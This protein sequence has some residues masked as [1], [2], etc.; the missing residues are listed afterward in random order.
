MRSVSQAFAVLR[1]LGE[2]APLTLSDI[3]R[4]L[5]L[6]ASSCFNLLGT[7]VAEGAVVREAPGKRYR[8]ADGWARSGLLQGGDARRMIDR[9]RPLM[10]RFAQEHGVTAGLWQV[11][12]RDRLQL[13]AHAESNAVLRIH[14]AQGQR[15]PLGGGAVGRAIAAA[16]TP[17]AEEIA[18]RFAAVRWEKPIAFADYAEQIRLAVRTGFALDDG[19]THIGIAT[20]AAVLPG[21]GAEYCLSAS[22]FAGARSG[23]EVTALGKAL[24]DL[25]RFEE[26]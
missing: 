3:A 8:L 4:S 10:M 7:L 5:G 18:R 26:A 25:A 6:G 23:A 12:A 2:S 19:Y 22:F 11:A 9:L 1:L 14:L 15:Q 20:L 13:V 24:V 21:R 16:Q 17:D